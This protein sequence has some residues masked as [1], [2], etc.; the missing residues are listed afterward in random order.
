MLGKILGLSKNNEQ[1]TILG[2]D[3]NR[4]SFTKDDINASTIPEK[5]M[6]VEFVPQDNKATNIHMCKAC[7]KE[8]PNIAFGITTVFI[9]LIFG[10]IGT[11]V[12]RF[13]FA[14]KPLKDVWLPTLM[15]LLISIVFF[16]PLIGFIAYIITTL[17]FTVTNYK[18]VMNQ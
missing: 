15:H 4:Y 1:G 18:I 3:E 7:F 14:R 16:I 8:E 12:S 17:Y 11:F 10:C 13:L 9:T 2:H 6:C 5:S